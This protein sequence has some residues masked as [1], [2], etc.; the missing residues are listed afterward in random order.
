M[1]ESLLK[2]PFDME[3]IVVRELQDGDKTGRYLH[4]KIVSEVARISGP[5]FY[6]FMEEMEDR[7]VVE[8]REED[9]MIGDMASKELWYHYTG[10]GTRLTLPQSSTDAGGD[11]DL[12]DLRPGFL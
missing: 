7:G 5:S 4:E 9:K 1:F 8:V 3:Q 10:G 6:G 2:K 12:G 11:L